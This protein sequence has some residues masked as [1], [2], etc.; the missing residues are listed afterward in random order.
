MT[1]L[2]TR[3]WVPKRERR[4]SRPRRHQRTVMDEEWDLMYGQ[5]PTWKEWWM[6]VTGKEKGEWPRGIKIYCG[7]MYCDEQLCVPEGL[8]LRVVQALHRA[9][10]HI[11][12][13]ILY[14]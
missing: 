8:M 9:A 11:G 5:S 7:K 13:D 1:C 2:A 12:V 10:G 6:I 3:H 14:E 4:N